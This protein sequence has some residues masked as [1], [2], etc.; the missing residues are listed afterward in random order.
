[1][2]TFGRTVVLGT[3]VAGTLDLS[4]AFVFAGMAGR[5]PVQVLRGV[6]SGP[7]GDQAASGGAA[8]ALAGLV[9]HYALMAVMVSVFALAAR[10]LGLL[11]RHP[12]LA[13]LAYGFCIYLVMYWIVL[14]LRFPARFPQVGW[15]PIGNALFSHLICVGL[16]IGLITARTLPR[17]GH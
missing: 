10:R 4:S 12:V 15:W 2:K 8:M 17:R 9:V 1:M 13:G 16:P 7:F 3:A 11:V 5:T 14:P 6:A